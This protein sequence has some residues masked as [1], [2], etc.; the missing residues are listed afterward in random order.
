MPGG[1]SVGVSATYALPSID[2]KEH[3]DVLTGT[4]SVD[5]FDA[6]TFF[7]S[8]ACFSF[9][10]DAFVGRARL[11]RRKISQPIVVNFAKGFISSTL[12][13]SGCSIFLADETFVANLM[14]IPLESF[15]VILGMDYL[16]IE[17]LY[18]IFGRQCLCRHLPVER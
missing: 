18:P 3:G 17:L 11:F 8:G 9:V 13:C 12:V 15:D 14:V 10:L 4:I 16:C 5:S 2:G 1:S 6:H 7:E